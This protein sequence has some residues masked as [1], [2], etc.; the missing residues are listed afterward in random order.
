[1]ENNAVLSHTIGEV[2]NFENQLR[3]SLAYPVDQPSALL[4]LTQPQFFARWIALE[5]ALAVDKMDVL[6]SSETAWASVV[7]Q[8]SS[9]VDEEVCLT[10]CGEGF[11]QMLLA[12]TD[13]YKILPQPGHRLQFLDLQLELLDEFR[14][15]LLQLA[16]QERSYD[17]YTKS[18]V[19]I[20]PILNTVAAVSSVLKDWTDLPFFLQLHS[21]KVQTELIERQAAEATEEK[22]LPWLRAETGNEQSKATESSAFDDIIELFERMQDDLLSRVVEGV[23][24][25]VK[26]KSQPY[27]LDKWASLPNP[28][29]FIQPSL[30]PT[31]AAMLQAVALGLQWLQDSLS[32]PLFTKAWQ[33]LA[34]QVSE[35]LYE[36]LI[37]QR[38]FNTG[39]VA[40]LNYDIHQNLLPLF[41][42][43]S[44]KPDS[45]FRDLKDACILL[46]LPNP[47]AMLLLD[48]LAQA[49]QMEESSSTSSRHIYSGRQALKDQGVKKLNIEEAL[50]VL[51]RRIL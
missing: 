30:S 25:E 40:Q 28:D 1:M 21:F 23:M 27:R 45:Y 11:L 15:R 10:E 18:S 2:L 47:V 39:G 3:S 44:T 22:L 49:V 7:D 9:D 13:R 33:K 17:T 31:A 38:Q 46:S 34:E 12:M 5:K 35:F 42:Q 36:E 20:C 24:L 29:A 19:N 8:D 14:V 37:L 41:S 6:L 4:V 26:A 51:R 43:Y 50:S 48:T 16:R 32:T